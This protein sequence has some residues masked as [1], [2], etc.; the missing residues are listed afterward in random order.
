MERTPRQ[1]R[2]AKRQ[3]L[4]SEDSS[5]V[6]QQNAG[7]VAIKQEH[8]DSDP[9]AETLDA[10]PAEGA[11]PDGLTLASSALDSLQVSGWHLLARQQ[12]VCRR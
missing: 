7:P 11:A 12:R 9:A 6:L 1:L 5:T 2:A 10:T 4:S 8:T 3:K